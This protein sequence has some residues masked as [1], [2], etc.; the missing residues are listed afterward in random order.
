[1]KELDSRVFQQKLLHH[2]AL[3]LGEKSLVPILC[4]LLHLNKSSVYNRLKGEKLL[5]LEELL[6]IANQFGISLD[7]FLPSASEKATFR[8]KPLTTPVRNCREYL[9]EIVSNFKLFND[10]PDL[11]VWFSTSTLPFFHHL[12]FRELA[13]FKIFAYARINWQLPYTESLRF[14][15]ATFPER[16]MYESLMKPILEYYNRLSTV[17]FW[18]DD[19]YDNTL[20]QIK[21]FANAGQLA[22]NS[23]AE[24]LLEQLQTLCVHQYEMA[25]QGHKWAVGTRSHVS[26]KYSGTFDLY[27]NEIAPLSITLLAESQ[28]LRGIFTVYDDPNF[29]F[30]ADEGLYGYTLKWMQKL[31]AKCVHISQDGEQNRRAYFNRL[32]DGLKSFSC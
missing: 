12:N 13:L 22:D 21:Y 23:I 5:S 2:L 25:K 6:L 24:M 20:R 8:F 3:L 27:Y 17:E 32:G 14:D 18:S 4:D 9:T 29:M 15:P 16:D 28:H 26:A 30:S 7:A 11:R 1:M 10:V 31:K 19:L